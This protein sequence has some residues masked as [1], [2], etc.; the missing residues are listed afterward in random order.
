MISIDEA[1]E[2]VLDAAEALPPIALPLERAWGY[3]LAESVV[4]DTDMP[5]FDRSMMDGYALAARFSGEGKEVVV[6]GTVPA[7]YFYPDPVPDGHAVK[8]MTGAPLPDGCDA[9]IP[10]EFTSEPE[11]GRVRLHSAVEPGDNIGFR[12][13]E[14]KRGD[15]ILAPGTPIDP[16]VAAVL[17]QVGKSR[18]SVHRR[19]RVGILV[20]GT[21]L[22]DPGEIPS[23]GKIRESNSF[24][25]VAQCLTWG[26]EPVRIGQAGDE[27]RKLAAAIS[28]GLE[29]DVLAIT[30]G[31]SMGEFDLVPDLLADLGVEI[32][33]HKV[34]QKPAKP[35]LFGKCGPTLVFG[36][37]GNPV[38]CF[39]GFE[40]YA[41]PAMRRLAGESEY[42]TR[43]HQGMSAGDFKVRSDREHLK[44]AAVEREGEI[45]RAHPVATRGSADIYSIVGTN[46]FARFKQGHYTV[47][48]D[49]TIDFFFHRGKSD[50]A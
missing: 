33:F 30:G 14:M 6:V 31:V 40:L 43:W 4:A 29:Y 5:A 15:E 44:P 12:G 20:T 1:V 13:E 21:E 19:P 22:V 18:I 50:G 49:E 37:P 48:A 2:I 8:I 3:A 7:G 17:A 27:R 32:I 38:A 35:M 46:A 11:G 25:L 10:V 16:A 23:R 34:A 28:A 26:A 45:W 42:R 41:G 47:P 9:V 24:G 36:L 39:L